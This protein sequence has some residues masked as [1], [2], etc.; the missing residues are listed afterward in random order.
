MRKVPA[1][2]GNRAALLACR[3]DVVLEQPGEPAACGQTTVFQQQSGPFAA[4]ERVV[5]AGDQELTETTSYRLIVP[6]FLWL[7][8]WP[9]RRALARRN[10]RLATGVQPWWAPPDR[11]EPRQAM[12]LGLVAAGSMSAAFT[13]TL[14]TQTANFAAKDFGIGK[15]GQG[16]GGVFVRAGIVIALPLAFAADRVGR[17]KM[18]VLAAWLAPF[19]SAL[20]ALAPNF[21]A[22]VMT[23]SV[24]RP[25]SLALELL[26]A[27]VITEEMPR[28]SRAYAVSVLAM[29]SGLGAG[30]AVNG[31]RL[32]DLGRSGWRLVYVL[33]LI[34]IVVAIDMQRRLPETLR[35]EQVHVVAPP[36][37][38]VR[39]VQISSVSF[40]GNMF[41]A[42]ASFFQNRY[43][44]EVR[45]MSAG[46]ISNFTLGTATP[47]ALGLVVGGRLADMYGRRLLMVLLAPTS[48]ALLVWSFTVDG[49]GLWAGAFGA[50][51]LGGAA[52]PAFSVYR[53][54]MFPTGNRGRAAGIITAA[55]LLGGS[56]GIWVAGLLLD[57]GWSYG[58]TMG[59]LALGEVITILIVLTTYPETAHRELDDLNPGER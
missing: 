52:Y 36:I 7:F 12:L 59:T 39:L 2:Q 5:V 45:G 44:D 42:P 43:L 34:W 29:A 32:A 22:L 14:F 30:I 35:F 56:I 55:A 27:V 47:A 48:T 11:L 46:G 24:A 38:R 53:T 49:A 54:E 1:T 17:R 19:F 26:L 10:S 3:D 41:V 8:A 31:L 23:Q 6:W 9:M 51:L 25:M 28:N 40:F 57:R 50:G 18:I 33:A 13:N 20:G 37:N 58:S 21:P 15:T 16:L 4:Y